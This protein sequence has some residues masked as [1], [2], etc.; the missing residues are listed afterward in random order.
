ML[1]A[2]AVQNSAVTCNGAGNGSATVSVTGGNGGYTYS[3]D[4]GDA[5]A[6]VSDLSGGDHIVYIT[7]SKG[8]S[9]SATVHIDE[10]AVLSASAVQ[11]SAVTCNGAGN[12]SATVSVTGGNGG[13]TYSW[14]NGDAT[15]TVSDLSGGD[16]IVYITDSKNCSTSATVHIDEPAVLSASAV[17]NSAVTCNGAGNGS[18]TVSVTGGNARLYLFM[19]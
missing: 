12:G 8:C 9:T 10:P 6:T 14:D 11:N 15:A 5:T 3:W 4:N 16:H 18:A 13:Y 7:D 17:Q 1:S 19:G 2:S